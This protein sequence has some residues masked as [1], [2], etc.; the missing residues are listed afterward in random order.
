[1]GLEM[2]VQMDGWVYEVV[3][4]KNVICRYHEG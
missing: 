3:P 1:M 4:L 2:V